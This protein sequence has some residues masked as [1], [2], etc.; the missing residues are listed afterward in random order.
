[1]TI[2]S[3]NRHITGPS[4]QGKWCCVSFWLRKKAETCSFQT[5]DMREWLVEFTAGPSHHQPYN[6]PVS[7]PSP[8][9]ITPALLLPLAPSAS[10][11]TPAEVDSRE[12]E[13][14]WFAYDAMAQCQSCSQSMGAYYCLVRRRYKRRR[15][16]RSERKGKLFVFPHKG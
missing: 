5:S 1:M 3:K 9:H 7:P 6:S 8:Q 10:P 15:K 13:I 12:T 14:V 2:N 16:K 11:L 4:V